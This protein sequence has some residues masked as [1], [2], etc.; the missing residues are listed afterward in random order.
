MY[1]DYGGYIRYGVVAVRLRIYYSEVRG[2]ARSTMF[3]TRRKAREII[4]PSIHI[5]AGGVNANSESSSLKRVMGAARKVRWEQY[6][7]AAERYEKNRPASDNE[8]H[9]L[10]DLR[11]RA[12]DALGANRDRGR[13][14]LIRFV[15]SVMNARNECVIRV[16][17]PCRFAVHVI[18]STHSP[19]EW[20]CFI[21]YQ[22][23]MRLVIPH[24]KDAVMEL[25]NTPQS[26]TL[27]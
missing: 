12:H 9:V 18:Q 23:H 17:P 2:G 11:R 16:S 13:R 5:E 7:Q 8:A 26:M 6:R 19:A 10:V 1:G 15:P 21:S 25:V 24:D 14:A 27:S 3:S 4:A 22:E 20:V